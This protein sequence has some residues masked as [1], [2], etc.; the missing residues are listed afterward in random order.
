MLIMLNVS[1]N[2]DTDDA[3]KTRL[4]HSHE[5]LDQLFAVRHAADEEFSATEK[6]IRRTVLGTVAL[7]ELRLAAM[8][9]L[10]S[11]GLT[12][13]EVKLAFLTNEK[14]IPLL[15]SFDD[16]SEHGYVLFKQEMRD[17]E[18]NVTEDSGATALRNYKRVLRHV[19]LQATRS[20]PS[21]NGNQVRPLLELASSTAKTIAIMEGAVFQQAG[22]TPSPM[23][24]RKTHQYAPTMPETD[25]EEEEAIELDKYE[26]SMEGV[27]DSF[28]PDDTDY[29][30]TLE[31]SKRDE[32]GIGD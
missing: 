28:E 23:G 4:T 24:G 25:V 1:E 6:V 22:A 14:L 27:M 30:N 9:Q 26:V 12:H 32:P 18:K 31:T 19:L 3:P 13:T 10:F 17:A 16:D 29:E 20:M 5:T 21:A 7:K 8:E 15:G 2:Q 11:E